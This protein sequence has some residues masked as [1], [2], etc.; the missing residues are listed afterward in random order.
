LI[1]RRTL[2]LLFAAA[3]PCAAVGAQPTAAFF[4]GSAPP[5]QSLALYDWVVIDADNAAH[6]PWQR[7]ADDAHVFCYLSVGEARGDRAHAHRHLA[8]GRNEGWQSEVMDVTSADWRNVLVDEA[9][10]LGERGCEGLFLDTLDSYRLGFDADRWPEAEDG[11]TRIITSL[12]EA[13]PDLDILLNR[14]FEIYHRV[15]SAT[16][17][18]TVEGLY[19]GWDSQAQ[20]YRDINEDERRWLL[21]ALEQVTD[22]GGH[23]VVIDYLPPAATDAERSALAERISGHGFTPWVT[24]VSLMHL[25][26]GS[27]THQ[28]REVALLYHPGNSDFA[29][30][31]AHILLGAVL[32]HYGLIV[33]PYDVSSGLPAPV[34]GHH[35]GLI[36]WFD[37]D[38][39]RLGPS[40][41]DWRALLDTARSHAVPIVMFGSL[42]PVGAE[43]LAALGVARAA[44]GGRVRATLKSSRPGYG[45]FEA[46][47]PDREF[48]PVPLRLDGPANTAWVTMSLGDESIVPVA[49]GPW[50]GYAL[51]PYLLQEGFAGQRRWLLNPFDF[52]EH[53]LGSVR[54]PVP[55]TTTENGERILISYVDG[56]GFPSRAEMPGTP[57]SAEVL[58]DAVF[59][60]IDL[61]H[62]VSIIEGE[63]AESGMYPRLAA[64]LEPLARKIFALPNVEIASHTY[65]HPFFW[66]RRHAIDTTDTLYGLGLPIEGYRTDLAREVIGS[67]DYIDRELAPEGK[68]TKLFL[69]SGDAL[70]SG[71]AV[72]LTAERGLANLNGGNTQIRDALP[73]LTNVSPQSRWTSGGWQ[74]YAPI[75]NE[76]VYTNDWTGPFHGFRRV[77]ET[78]QRTDGARRLKPMSIYY[79]FY[80]GTKPGALQALLDVY[81]YAR[82]Q[83]HTALFASE[84]S[85]RVA[86]YHS[87]RITRTAQGHWH[88]DRLGALRTLRLPEAVP[89]PDLARSLNVAGWRSTRSGTYVHLTADH[90]VLVP[91]DSRGTPRLVSANGRVQQWK[92]HADGIDVSIEA[93]EPLRLTV[94]A[95]ATCRLNLANGNTVQPALRDA[96]GQHFRLR[97]RRLDNARLRC[98]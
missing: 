24:D 28:P 74:V 56:D 29:G 14:G 94:A 50:G 57:F 97:A 5:V 8:V 1:K 93:Y 32:D 36:T 75:M 52:I 54:A 49:T 47:A 67:S 80:S 78:F 58:H 41:D 44:N 82:S 55:D 86:G 11:L 13:L 92:Q 33:R 20:R 90:A 61:P 16:V 38:T 45:D 79:H 21:E 25:G 59:S 37:G 95:A 64:E 83:P 26:V 6:A 68:R 40:R 65:S 84:F 39:T 48:V 46:P 10:A 3:L 69:W 98:G 63:I 23:V 17:G 91:G 81:A 87:A 19:R 15:A 35:A 73:S 2:M 66:A 85:E 96:D 70:P 60:A 43:T 31:D 42:P 27:F 12:G 51:H 34:R 76:N 9:R 62:T 7:L 18:M 89:V 30:H 4:Y 71:E 72:A 22:S 88:I 77:I 53:A